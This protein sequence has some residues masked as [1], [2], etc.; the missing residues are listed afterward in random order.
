MDGAHNAEIRLCEGTRIEESRSSTRI[1]G[2]AP[3]ARARLDG[4][5]HHRWPA[6]SAICGQ[7]GAGSV[8]ARH[9][10]T[11]GGISYRSRESL[12]SE[13]VGPINDSETVFASIDAGEFQDS[14]SGECG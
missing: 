12:D 1:T 9:G 3:R 14:S 2:H 10:D 11:Y 4:R 7:A 13:Y 6:W 8:G 5:F